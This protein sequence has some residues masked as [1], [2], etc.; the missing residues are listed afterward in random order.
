MTPLRQTAMPLRQRVRVMRCRFGHMALPLYRA[1][2]RGGRSGRIVMQ[3]YPDLQTRCRRGHVA[4]LLYRAQ[5][6]GSRF[7]RVVLQPYRALRTRSRSSHVAMPVLHGP[8][9]GGRSGRV[10]VQGYQALR[11]RSRSGHRQQLSVH[12]AIGIQRGFRHQ[13]RQRGYRGK[14]RAGAVAG[15]PRFLQKMTLQRM[16]M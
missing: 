4:M 5:M 9:Q 10:V 11:T 8:V 2:T 15:L 7:G 6:R 12:W 1:L 16:R 3:R 13:A 14:R